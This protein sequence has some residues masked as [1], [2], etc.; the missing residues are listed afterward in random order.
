MVYVYYVYVENMTGQK[1]NYVLLL[2]LLKHALELKIRE[3]KLPF[4]W[5]IYLFN[6]NNRLKL[7]LYLLLN[8]IFDHDKHIF[9]NH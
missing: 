9:Y 8:Y 3:K 7:L 2:L 4:E 5:N 6:L 1:L